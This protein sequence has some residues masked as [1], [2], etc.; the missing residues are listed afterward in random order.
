A[1]VRDTDDGALVYRRMAVED[2]FNL[3]WIDVLAA[4]NKHVLLAVLD[5]EVPFLIHYCQISRMEPALVVDGF[6]GGLRVIVIARRVAGA[7]EHQLANV[8]RGQGIVLIVHHARADEEVGPADAARF[9]YGIFRR[10]GENA[11]TKLGHAKTLLE[12]H[13]FFPGVF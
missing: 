1:L 10:Q 5:V 12:A 11:G 13:A 6:D 2:G 7:L 4:R 3:G 8:P 9:A